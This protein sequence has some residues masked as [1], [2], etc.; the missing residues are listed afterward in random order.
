MI[1]CQI[2]KTDKKLKINFRMQQ[3]TIFMNGL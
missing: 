3:M 2:V 1:F